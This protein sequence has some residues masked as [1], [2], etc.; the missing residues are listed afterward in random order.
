M[1]EVVNGS[2]A[3]R[4]LLGI[5][6]FL[7]AGT[8]LLFLRGDPR[9]GD[10]ARG[11]IALVVLVGGIFWLGYRYRVVPR[12]ESFRGQSEALAFRAEPGDPLGLLDVPFSLFRWLGSVRRI[13][14]TATGVHRGEPVTIVDYWFAPSSAERYDDHERYTCV[15]APAGAAWS[16]LLVVPERWTSRLRS[17]VGI[18]D[19][20]AESE[21][22]NRAF[23][24]RA[25]DR[26]FASA[27]ADA[28]MIAWL[29]EQGSGLGFE[30]LDGRVMVFRRRE[31]ASLEDVADVLALY[32]AF[33]DHVPRIHHGTS[34]RVSQLASASSSPSSAPPASSLPSQRSVPSPPLSESA[35]PPANSSSSPSSPNSSSSPGPASR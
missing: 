7:A 3:R 15:I 1:G 16:D 35:P 30:I 11:L 22:F 28:R 6:A 25:A 31:T 12:R 13:E 4:I 27:F 32:D 23:H 18:R 19:V 10:T 24:V 5:G 20:E 29:L 14:N 26:R 8:V 2:T 33:A 17:A 21:R 34:T 9:A